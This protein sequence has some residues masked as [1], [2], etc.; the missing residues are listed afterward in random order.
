MDA[1]K[2]AL[3]R[4]GEEAG[5]KGRQ[6]YHPIRLALTG[7]DSGPELV[8]LLTLLRAGLIRERVRSVLN[9]FP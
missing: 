4:A 9:F 8:T 7:S 1:A 5:A 6:L 2:I 3:R